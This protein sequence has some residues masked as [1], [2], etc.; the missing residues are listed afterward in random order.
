TRC[1]L[2]T[3]TTA[4]RTRLSMGASEGSGVPEAAGTAGRDAAGTGTAPS[5]ARAGGTDCCSQVAAKP[6]NAA[7]AISAAS[8]PSAR[9]GRSGPGRASGAGREGG[10]WD[11]G[12]MIVRVGSGPRDR[13]QHIHSRLRPPDPARSFRTCPRAWPEPTPDPVS[14]PLAGRSGTPRGAAANRLTGS[15]PGISLAA[16]ATTSWG[17]GG[18]SGPRA[19]G[20][21]QGVEHAVEHHEANTRR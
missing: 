19:G 20:R 3:L 7:A 8:R 6:P 9:R 4:G 16:P 17:A 18:R 5:L 2:C 12:D 21:A 13:G 14:A 11:I 15:D 1:L 10:V